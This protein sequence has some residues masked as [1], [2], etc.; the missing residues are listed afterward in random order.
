VLP[1]TKI[2]VK[3][4]EGVGSITMTDEVSNKEIN[5]QP[6]HNDDECMFQFKKI[7]E[8]ERRTFKLMKL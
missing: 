4:T 2:Y 1:N 8:N 5:L 3:C 6:A 7:L